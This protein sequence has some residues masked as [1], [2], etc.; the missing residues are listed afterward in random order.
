VESSARRLK[1]EGVLKILI[2]YILN[3]VWAYF[4]GKP[5]TKDHI[6]VR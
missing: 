1:K 5:F 2:R 6:D 4:F 3:V